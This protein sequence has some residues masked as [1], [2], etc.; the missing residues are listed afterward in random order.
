MKKLIIS[1][2]PTILVEF[3]YSNFQKIYNYLKSYYFCY[4]YMFDK[5]IFLKLK[6]NQIKKM[7]KK[8]S[9]DTKYTKNSFNVFFIPKEIKFK[10]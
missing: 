4:L 6:N 1:K 5:N 9:L 3:N 8:K 7:Y 10:F 2:K